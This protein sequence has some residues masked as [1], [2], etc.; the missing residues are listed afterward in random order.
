VIWTLQCILG[1]SNQ[2]KMRH[3]NVCITHG[4]VKKKKKRALYLE[5]WEDVNVFDT[6]TSS[7]VGGSVLDC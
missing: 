5:T 3:G 4:E 2:G 1:W 6:I 7:D